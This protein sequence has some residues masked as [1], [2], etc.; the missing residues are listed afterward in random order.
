MKL[1]IHCDMNDAPPV[2]ANLPVCFREF[3]PHVLGFAFACNRRDATPCHNGS[4]L[5]P[6]DVSRILWMFFGPC[7]EVIVVLRNDAV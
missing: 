2:V 1:G 3:A 5:Q 7:G 4:K 6:I